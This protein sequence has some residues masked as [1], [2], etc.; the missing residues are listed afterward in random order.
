MLHT[1]HLEFS[2]YLCTPKI[3]KLKCALCQ[4]WASKDCSYA[5]TDLFT[6]YKWLFD[7]HDDDLISS[8]SL[9]DCPLRMGFLNLH[10]SFKF[11]RG[12]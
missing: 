10:P 4:N 2:F 1:R 5:Q 11:T 9:I 8:N 6:L 7:F 12:F 3:L